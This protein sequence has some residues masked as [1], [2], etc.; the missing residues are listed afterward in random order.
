MPKGQ[1]HLVQCRCVLPQYKNAKHP[2][3]HKFIVFSEINDDDSV[4]PKFAQCNNCG[5][6]HKVVDLCKSEVMSGK[7]AMS[8]IKSVDDIK[9]GLPEKL[10]QTLESNNADLPT[11]EAV[12][13]IIENKQWGSFVVLSSDE[14]DGL[15]QGK[16]VRLISENMFRVETYSR[17]EVLK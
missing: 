4:K 6:I 1:K 11:W 13:F 10:V 12:S 15:K 14:E 5:I 8:S 17:E 3:I 16:Y 9:L 2:L 7:E